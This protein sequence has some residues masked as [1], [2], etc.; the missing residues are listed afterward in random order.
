M[1]QMQE[2][3]E[4][5]VLLTAEDVSKVLSLGRS[6]VFQLFARGELPVVRVG[7][8]VWVRRVDVER[9]IDEQAAHSGTSLT[10]AGTDS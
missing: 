2:A 10:E 6:T 4:Q 9:W 8:A 1:S 3:P 5:S 7:R